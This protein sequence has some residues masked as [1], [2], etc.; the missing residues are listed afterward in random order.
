MWTANL[1]AGKRAAFVNG[2][3]FVGAHPEP[4]ASAFGEQRPTN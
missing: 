2:G 1:D 4:V 3:E